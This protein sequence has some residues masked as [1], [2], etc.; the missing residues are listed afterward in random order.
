MH[1]TLRPSPSL[2]FAL[3]ASAALTTPALAQSVAWWR[4]DEGVEGQATSGPIL[5]SIMSFNGIAVGFPRYGAFFDDCVT[6]GLEFDG[7]DD[8]V[9]LA[10][11]AAFAALRSM[12]V[13]AIFRTDGY[14]FSPDGLNQIV[15]RG[16]D[17]GALDPFF[18]ALQSSGRV[19]FFVN[20]VRVVETP[21]AIPVG[22]VMHIAATLDDTT[23]MVKLFVDHQVVA[24][25]TTT[26]RPTG[27]L[28][29]PRPGL[30]IGNVQ[31]SS[32]RQYFDGTMYE[33]RLSSLALA[34]ESMLLVSPRFALQPSSV[35]ACPGGDA[36][37]VTLASGLQN[38]EYQ[39]Q[40]A[41]FATP[42]GWSEL[43]DGSLAINGIIWG[44]LT[45]ARTSTLVVSPDPLTYFTGSL[46]R[47]RCIVSNTCGSV[48]S[49]PATLSICLADFNCDSAV[50]GDDVIAFF[51]AWDAG[52]IEAD[53]NGDD[54]VD[55]DD[56]IAFFGAWDGGC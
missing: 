19:G 44:T 7:D 41:D 2:P 21:T 50:D 6:G 23:G 48:I 20:N 56:V 39:W 4:F 26:Q 1:T 33:V 3:A 49:N 10:D 12:T 53:V 34:A 42:P 14:R 27:A 46:L 24:Q 45:G 35:V 30:G 18:L 28:T 54:S 36:S 5:D 17:R 32:F 15:F 25:A 37:I 40:I 55:G 29:G 11:T 38:V 52:Q 8:R 16:D 43:I 22:P 13:E 51:T 47:F 31:S 9:A